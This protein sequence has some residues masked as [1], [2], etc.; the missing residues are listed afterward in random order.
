MS[1]NNSELV[2]KI[3]LEYSSPF[4]SEKKDASIILAAGHGKRIK[5]DT[6]KMLHKIW[7]VPTVNRAVDACLK[8]IPGSNIIVVV[9]IKAEEVIKSVGKNVQTS[10]AYQE[11]QHGTGHAVQ[12]ALEN[13]P[14]DFDGTIYV[15]PGD[16]GLIDATTIKFFKY[17][18][19]NSKSD[20]MVLTGIYEGQIEENHYGRII[21]VKGK[22]AKGVKSRY[23]GR[24]IQIM[25]Y[26]DILGLDKKEPYLT[27][28]KKKPFKFT[29]AELLDNREFNSGVYAFKS[30]PLFELIKKLQNNNAQGEIYITDLIALFNDNGYNVEAISPVDQ[31]V[32]MGFNNKSVLKEM[33]GIAQKLIYEKI[34]DIVLVDDPNDFFIAE[35]VVQNFLERDKNGEILDIEIG[36]GVYIGTGITLASKIKL[37]KN[38]RLEGNVTIGENVF[39]DLGTQIY[40]SDEY[41]CTIGDK[42]KFRGIN[43]IVGSQ[44][45]SDSVI[46]HS[47]LVNTEVSDGSILKFIVPEAVGKENISNL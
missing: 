22:D 43:Y 26:K 31:F 45:G 19:E 33:D 23:K 32:L 12:V 27:K 15:F 18:F 13:I 20:M 42:V 44:I 40:G 2:K 9:G 5:S 30:K 38:V 47:I 41:P 46:M 10:Y 8:G 3:I 11:V 35:D 21:R 17:E 36:K 16:M 6:S 4:E 7:E 37:M 28:Y 14:N 24:V 29:R 39:V 34:K 1:E 25:E